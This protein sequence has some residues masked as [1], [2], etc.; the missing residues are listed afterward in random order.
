M[1]ADVT[2]PSIPRMFGIDERATGSEEGINT[3]F[4]SFGNPDDVYEFAFRE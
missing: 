1:D 4:N 2:G 3:V